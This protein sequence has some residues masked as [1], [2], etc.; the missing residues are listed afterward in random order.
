MGESSFPVGPRS[1][2]P[3]HVGV[4]DS[5][6]GPRVERRKRGR[7][8]RHRM[9]PFRHSLSVRSRILVSILAVTALGLTAAGVASSLVQRERVLSAVDAGL[10]HSV[11]ELKR[12]AAGETSDAPPASVDALFRMAMR[13]MIPNSDE[14]I[15]GF[16]D[17]KPALVPAANLPFR[18]DHEP[19]LV[20]RIAAEADAT[21]VVIGTAKTDIGS[22]RYL[23]VPVAVAGDP[24]RGLYVSAHNLNVDLAAVADSSR[25]YT[26]VAVLALLLVGLV[27]WFVAGRLLRPIRLLRAA[28]AGSSTAADLTDRIPVRGRDD[29]S[30][31]ADTINGMFDR[32]QESSRSQRRLLDDIGHE[33]KTPIT[34]IRG[35]LELLDPRNPGDVEAT[36]ALTIDELDRMSTLVSEISLLAESRSPRFIQP[37]DV[38]IESFTASIGAKASAFDPTRSWLVESARG[39][40]HIDERRLTQAWLQLA[41]NAA[42]YSTPATPIAISSQLEHAKSRVWLNL[43]VSDTGPGIPLESRARVFERFERLGSKRDADGSGLGLAIV[44]AI[45]EAHGGS[46]D[47]AE[48]AKQGAVFVIRIPL[49]S[50]VRQSETVRI[51][52]TKKGE[53]T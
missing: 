19:A 3:H 43:A 23:I 35:H 53:A 46:V 10:L 9:R 37:A 50:P 11:S 45:A 2:G 52:Q 31:L 24:S 21:R 30:E 38:D 22:L 6:R 15:V 5:R 7:Y 40:A 17:G 27:A 49:A 1:S 18:I 32:L 12:I 8:R 20:K 34:I 16:I 33:L 13:Q 41:D 42:K 48:S 14:S 36:R 28:A 51:Q 29:V 26:G 47:L 25:T 39:V 4:V 44:A